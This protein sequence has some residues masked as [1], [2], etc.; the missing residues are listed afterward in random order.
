MI[1]LFSDFGAAG[2]TDPED[3]LTHNSLGVRGQQILT[4]PELLPSSKRPQ[5]CSRLV[6]SQE[7]FRKPGSCLHRLCAVKAAGLISF[8]ISSN[9][10]FHYCC[11][12]GGGFIQ[13]ANQHLLNEALS[14]RLSSC[15]A[16][17]SLN[18]GSHLFFP[19]YKLTSNPF[20]TGLE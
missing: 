11:A 7:T 10:R 2:F 1:F 14:G 5:V 3:P 19:P 18:A 17:L 9:K 13:Q 4:P 6:F 20:F 15:S 16:I 12:S 8:L